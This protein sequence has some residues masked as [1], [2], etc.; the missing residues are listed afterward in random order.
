MLAGYVRRAARKQEH[1]HC[2]DLVGRGQ[3]MKLVEHG[4]RAAT[5]KNENA[6]ETV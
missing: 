5:T 2:R 3:T 4:R 1:Y 6:D